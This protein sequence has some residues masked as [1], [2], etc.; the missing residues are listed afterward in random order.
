MGYFNISEILTDVTNYLRDRIPNINNSIK[1]N[2]NLGT[3]EVENIYLSKIL[4]EWTIEN[5]IKN[6]L[7]AIDFS[8]NGL[9]EVKLSES[10]SKIMIDIKDNG[11]G[12][13]LNQV[14]NIF[15]TGYT[16][17]KRGWGIGLSLAKRV[18]EE[19]HKGKIYVLNSKPDVGTTI[20]VVLNKLV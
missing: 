6:S 8:K 16:T 12:L 11:K 5:I 17:K 13:K 10:K 18:I 1:I 3:K 7:Q 20:R 19:Y 14:K 4:I 9:I 15:N 2:L